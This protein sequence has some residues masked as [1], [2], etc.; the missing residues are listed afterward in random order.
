LAARYTAKLRDARVSL[1]TVPEGRTHIFYRYVVG[2]R[3]ADR[4][5]RRLT[6]S[7]IEAKRPV[8]QP[9]HRYVAAGEFPKT[10][11]AMR[12]ALSLPLHPSLDD[13]AVDAVASAVVRECG[14]HHTEKEA[15]RRLASSS[16]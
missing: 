13:A 1:P 5:I 12:S 4:L 3:D 16:R 2:V 8:F 6:A 10:D 11:V 14:V 9:L 15:R 7:E